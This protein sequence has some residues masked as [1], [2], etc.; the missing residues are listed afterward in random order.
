MKIFINLLQYNI[1]FLLLLIFLSNHKVECKM[2]FD[3]FNNYFSNKTLD[4]IRQ[5]YWNIILD[6][7]SKGIYDKSI[8]FFKRNYAE[9]YLHSINRIVIMYKL[10][11]YYKYFDIELDDFV[12]QME[13]IDIFKKDNIDYLFFDKFCN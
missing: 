9:E 11:D 1:F 6:L 5:I 7:E 4:R 8:Q 10:E 3:E 12:A 2:S 13:K